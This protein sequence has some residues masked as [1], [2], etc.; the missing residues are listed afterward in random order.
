MLRIPRRAMPLLNAAE[1]AAAGI[2]NGVAGTGG[3][4]LLVYLFSRLESTYDVRLGLLSA[5]AVTLPMSCVSLV[6]YGG[7]GFDSPSAA[8]AT[9]VPA[10][11][12]GALGGLIGE[13]LPSRVLRIIFALVVI[14]GGLS[15]I[16]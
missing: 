11:L 9:V 13:R 5:M 1:A 8:A 14:R 6:T 7:G 3:G 4:T 12:G 2:I 16:F 10:L 15:M